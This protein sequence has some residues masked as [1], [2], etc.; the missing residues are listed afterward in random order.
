[1]DSVG[2]GGECRDFGDAGVNVGGGDGVVMGGSVDVIHS[3]LI[4]FW[5]S[6]VQIFRA[7]L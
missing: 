5:I 1:M 4:N 6:V 7:G 3:L 2:G